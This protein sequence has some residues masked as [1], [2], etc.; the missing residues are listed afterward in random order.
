MPLR[1]INNLAGLLAWSP[2][3]NGDLRSVVAVGTKDSG[4]I[5]FD[6]YG[7]D[8]E[9][10]DLCLNQGTSSSTPEVKSLGSVKTSSRFASISWTSMATKQQE[11]PMGLIA[12]GMLDGT[13]N[14][15]DPARLVNGHEQPQL[16]SINKHT[17]GAV[18]GLQFNPHPAS[19]HL[20]ASGGS[21]GEVY[22]MS[23]ENPETPNVFVPAPPPNQTKHTSEISKIAW[24]T[25]VAHIVASASNNGSAIVWD[26]RQKKP[27]CELREANRS[28]IS[29]ICWN[30][31][32]G[33]HLITASSDD[34]NPVVKLWDLRAS[35]TMPLAT[36]QGHTQ[37]ILGVSW[38]PHD[39]RL[40][41]STGKDNKTIMW[42]LF[43]LKSIAELPSGGE[44][45]AAPSG[46]NANS[47]GGG[48][49]GGM[50]ASQQK[51]YDIQWSPHCR[52]VLATC[53]FDRKIQAHSVV[54]AGQASGKAPKWLQRPAGVTMGYGGKI[55]K[56]N[57]ALKTG[58][59]IERMVEEPVLKAAS[60][61]FEGM[62]ANKDYKGFC[63]TKIA[64]SQSEKERQVWGFMSL[65]FEKNA[66]EQLVQY[67]GFDSEAINK[68][69]TELDPASDVSGGMKESQMGKM[70]EDAVS[71][72]LLVGNFEA[73]VECCFKN[74]Q[75]ADALILSSCGG[76][77]LWQKAQAMYFE[78][79]AK[80]RPYLNI[81]N[82]VINNTLSDLVVKSD[83]GKWRETLAILSTYGKSE[84]FPGLCE[85]LGAR[86]QEA[87]DVDSAALCFMSA[88]NIEKTVTFWKAELDQALGMGDNVM[89]LH[90][91]IE[92]VT[93]FSQME[94]GFAF[95]EDVQEMFTQYAEA[96]ANQGL[97]WLA[98]QDPSSGR[99]YYANQQTGATTWDPPPM[100]IPAAP[101][102]QP[103]VMQPPIPAQQV[104]PTTPTKPSFNSA[105]LA[106]KYGDGFV[107]SA[108]NPELAAQYGNIGTANPYNGAA[109]PA[110]ANVAG[111]ST[112][113]PHQVPSQPAA[114]PAPQVQEIPPELMT[115][116]N[117]LK[118]LIGALEGA[119]LAMPEKKQ[120]GEISKGCEILFVKL[121][122]P[123][124]ID[125]DTAGKLQ[126]LVAALQNKDYATAGN[127]ST[128][129]ANSVWRQHKDF[130]KGI[131]Y[132]I[133]LA[134]K[135]L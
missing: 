39:P 36:L 93:V 89:A 78:R 73:A 102:P 79:E 126:T 17:G 132:L 1:E 101:V 21:D 59:A 92:K 117:G 56:F 133:Q 75:L 111:S 84:E 99:T 118:G 130:L 71:K 88:L 7:G 129:L 11:F 103:Q 134:G 47:I 52:G 109:R 68:L 24:N 77:E 94:A 65:I 38:C 32:E 63:E 116:V 53:S 104:N 37:G 4:S 54:G 26:L 33:L 58:V 98:M 105:N 82:A 80:S 70:A 23:L 50:G 85:A 64:N 60:E 14:V 112:G 107:S 18:G 113:T 91:F 95:P 100:P 43:S 67:L 3:G 96:L 28:P 10:Y 90:T 81:V 8:L 125:P 108:S 72:A 86:L 115:V 12:G 106:N 76:V 124:A 62:M 29:D 49:F 30:P 25:Q 120:L 31:T 69:A 131:K 51:R 122:T 83:L 19:S 35:T 123:N 66:R 114:E 45:E 48:A 44:E 41:M 55:V 87:G 2:I 46:G 6:D 121:A 128:L 40:L 119:Q 97:G 57:A 110:G 9:L 74:G 13:V 15:W 34:A 61:Y 27:W 127:M 16:T 20:L 42:D 5:G 22:I 135:K